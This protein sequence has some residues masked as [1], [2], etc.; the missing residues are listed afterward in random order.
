MSE[1]DAEYIKAAAG[2]MQR[3]CDDLG[4]EV[5]SGA[6]ACALALAAAPHI[7]A[8]E[9]ERIAALAERMEVNY[10]TGSDEV[11]EIRLVLPFADL[12]REEGGAA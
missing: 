2:A 6:L 12:I 8:A 3:H 4:I 10:L 7:R 5:P 11:S 9:R 1:I